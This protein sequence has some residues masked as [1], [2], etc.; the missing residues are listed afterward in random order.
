MYGDVTY[1]HVVV[2]PSA[3]N[4]TFVRPLRAAWP[5]AT[6]ISVELRPEEAQNLQEAGSTFVAIGDWTEWALKMDLKTPALCVG[7]PPFSL[8]QSHLEAAFRY[9]PAGSNIVLLLRFSFFGGNER[10]QTFWLKEGG[11]FLKHIIPIAPRP[12]FV[13]G[14]SDNSEYA[15]FIWEVGF[16]RE[17]TVLPPLLW[18]KRVRPVK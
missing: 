6:I 4:G 17:A 16:S 3:G 8:A 2:E 13:K 5:R 10:N 9:L 7:N 15:L 18:E 14:T 1:S 11:K 12:S